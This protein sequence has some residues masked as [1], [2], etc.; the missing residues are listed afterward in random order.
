MATEKENYLRATSNL[1]FLIGVN[2]DCRSLE[3]RMATLGLGGP[4]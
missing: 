1:A 4:N 2:V 3:R